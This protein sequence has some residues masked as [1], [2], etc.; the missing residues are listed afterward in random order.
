MA[1]D[2]AISSS[3]TILVQTVGSNQEHIGQACRSYFLSPGGGDFEG[4]LS[5]FT[6][7]TA[8]ARPVKAVLF[9]RCIRSPPSTMTMMTVKLVDSLRHCSC[10]EESDLRPYSPLNEGDV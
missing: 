5:T 2:I 7:P 6:S 3:K 9:Y 8:S 10:C 1:I 4:I